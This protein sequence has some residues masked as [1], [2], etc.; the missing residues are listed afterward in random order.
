M[1]DDRYYWHEAYGR[2]PCGCP[3]DADALIDRHTGQAVEWQCRVCGQ[4]TAS[5][6]VPDDVPTEPR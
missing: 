5:P 1:D 2:G 6:D 4:R 3:C